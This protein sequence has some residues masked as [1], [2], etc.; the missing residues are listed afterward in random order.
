MSNIYNYGKKYKLSQSVD[1]ISK[2]RNNKSNNIKVIQN[3]NINDN[4][5][6]NPHYYSSNENYHYNY[7]SNS[8][9][10]NRN[11]GKSSEKN[12]Y[13]EKK[14]NNYNTYN[15]S[16][17]YK[18]FSHYTSGLPVEI[19]SKPRFLFFSFLMLLFCLFQFLL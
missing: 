11:R 7:G 2:I 5:N 14:V 15:Y 19:Y 17:N 6:I 16:Y 9:Q 8:S 4:I 12:R 1:H 10:I 13:S 18:N 3:N